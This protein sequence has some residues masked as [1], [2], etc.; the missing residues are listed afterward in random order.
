MLS[1]MK[2]S[3]IHI[4]QAQAASFRSMKPRKQQQ[5]AG[6]RQH[7][8]NG[9][10]CSR[11]TCLTPRQTVQIPAPI[12]SHSPLLTGLNDEQLAAVTLPAGHALIPGG[13]RLGQ[14][15]RADH[16]HRLAAADRAGHA[17]SS[18]P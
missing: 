18:W 4:Y 9:G 12:A 6:S 7:F 1:D 3:E 14:D 16:A 15:A 2:I 11:S 10:L 8:Y 17:G 5:V 13:C